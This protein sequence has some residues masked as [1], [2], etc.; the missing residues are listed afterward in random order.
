MRRGEGGDDICTLLYGKEVEGH[1]SWHSKEV[2][3]H[4]GVYFF[5]QTNDM[6]KK[7]PQKDRPFDLNVQLREKMRQGSK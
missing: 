3:L 6:G 1:A 4:L 5:F 7:I 2:F